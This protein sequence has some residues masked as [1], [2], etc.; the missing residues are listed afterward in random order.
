MNSNFP[1]A[2]I[3]STLV[4]IASGL[5]ILHN[6]NIIHRDLKCANIFVTK[7]GVIKLGDLNV[8]KVNKKG[9]AYTQ[10]GTPYY[11]SPEVWRDKPYTFSSDIWSLGCVIYEIA[12][13]DPPFTATDMQGLYNKITKGEYPNISH[14]YSDNLS[15]MIRHLLQVNPMLR[16]TCDQILD[17]HLAQ[18]YINLNPASEGDSPSLLQTIKFEPCMQNLK[19]KFPS[20]T[21]DEN[22][23]R[24]GNKKIV[25][26]SSNRELSAKAT[27]D[28]YRNYSLNSREAVKV[29][30]RKQISLEA[31]ERPYKNNNL[32]RMQSNGPELLMNYPVDKSPVISP[33]KQLIKLNEIPNRKVPLPRP[34]PINKIGMMILET[35]KIYEKLTPIEKT[36]QVNSN[37]NKEAN[38]YYSPQNPIWFG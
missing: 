23:G 16:F 7:D 32:V 4:Q 24:T 9:L 12:A 19:S 11:A 21:Y 30:I 33:E 27:P 6:G 34:R 22:R 25:Q 17:S 14:I 8:S 15:R 26:S 20:P 5:K 1:E 31:L 35:P 2:E 29:P 18:K 37:R 13:L 10:T 28:Y 38:V 3:W 36:P